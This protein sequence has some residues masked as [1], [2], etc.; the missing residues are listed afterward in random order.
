MTL[1]GTAT[2]GLLLCFAISGCSFDVTSELAP[3]V[4]SENPG[5]LGETGRSTGL[6]PP[7]LPP[8]EP[9]PPAPAGVL[10]ALATKDTVVLDGDLSE[11]TDA[12]WV[13][14]AATDGGDDKALWTRFAPDYVA[15]ASGHIAAFHGPRAL[16]LAVRIVDDVLRPDPNVY[17]NGDYIEVFIDGNADASGPYDADDRVLFVPLADPSSC[18]FEQAPGP[19]VC[20]ADWQPDGWTVEIQLGY[21]GLGWLSTPSEIGFGVGFFDDDGHDNDP[22]FVA[23]AIDAFVPWHVSNRPACDHCC[24]AGPYTPYPQ[25][26]CDTSRLGRLI[27]SESTP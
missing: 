6:V 18:G 1:R 15:S 26:W 23:D 22:G 7:A 4:V 10:L 12:D 8:R 11:W 16:Y 24:A 2:A 25:P 13:D 19:A 9:E 20:R 3:G 14:F 27:F 21:R 5:E 17:W